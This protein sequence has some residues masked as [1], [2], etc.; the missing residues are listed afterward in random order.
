MPTPLQAANVVAG[1]KE[2]MNIL[3]A[4][5]L[6]LCPQFCSMSNWK[7]KHRYSISEDKHQFLVHGYRVQLESQKFEACK[8]GSVCR[9][10]YFYFILFYF[11]LFYLL[12]VS[13]LQLSSDTPE[14]GIRFRYGWC[15]PPCGCWDLNSGPLE[16]QLPPLTTEPSHQP[17]SRLFKEMSRKMEPRKSC[18][19]DSMGRVRF[20]LN[21]A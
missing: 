1:F 9:C 17:S 10:A 13:T 12:Y 4:A 5:A 7:G 19:S 11:I 3:S 14:E 18:L 21:G 16:E 15:E 6:L 8:A 20:I 2:D